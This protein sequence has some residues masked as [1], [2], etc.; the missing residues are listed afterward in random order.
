MAVGAPSGLLIPLAPHGLRAVPL[1]AGATAIGGFGA[2][3]YN[4]QQVSLRQ[5]ITPERRQGRMNATMRFL[6]WGTIPLGSLVGGALA[7]TIVCYR[8]GCS[9]FDS[10][11]P[12]EEPALCGL[13]VWDLFPVFTS[14]STRPQTRVARPSRRRWTA[15]ARPALAPLVARRLRV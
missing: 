4:I 7:A 1:L 10:R 9:E 8:A 14:K 13:F 6:V 12:D 3:V 11:R 15:V 2:V 5:T